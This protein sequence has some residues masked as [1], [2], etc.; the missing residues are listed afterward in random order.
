M[1]LLHPAHLHADTVTFLQHRSLADF[2]C[3]ENVSHAGCVRP[4]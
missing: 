1:F 3:G 4:G 2:G